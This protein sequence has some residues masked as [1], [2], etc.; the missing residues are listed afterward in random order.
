MPSFWKQFT[1]PFKTVGKTIDEWFKKK[2][3]K[4]P[5]KKAMTFKVGAGLT[6]E[7]KVTAEKK[8]KELTKPITPLKHETTKQLFGVGKRVSP[9]PEATT[10]ALKGM[11]TGVAKGLTLGY[12][13]PKFKKTEIEEKAAKI[14]RPIG[15]MESW[16]IPFGAAEKGLAIAGKLALKAP[17][18]A[19]IAKIGTK[20]MP[21]LV[22]KMA[23]V[24]LP[25][26]AISG[27]ERPT[28]GQT[29]EEAVAHGALFGAAFPLAG[30]ALK[31]ITKPMMKVASNA[32][33]GLV[34]KP[35]TIVIKGLP[36]EEQETL[37]T[38]GIKGE[39]LAKDIYERALRVTAGV[40]EIAKKEVSKTTALPAEK[41]AKK[42]INPEIAKIIRKKGEIITIPSKISLEVKEKAA[43]I[44]EVK[45]AIEPYMKI[46][47][48]YGFINQ[49]KKQGTI[50]L[51]EE[52][53]DLG[54][55]PQI[56][57]HPAIRVTYTVRPYKLGYGC[58]G[59]TSGNV[60][61]LAKDMAQKNGLNFE[62]IAK[63]V[64]P[65]EPQIKFI[66]DL[67]KN[68]AKETIIPGAWGK[69][70]IEM[71]IRDLHEINYHSLA[72]A[73]EKEVK[74]APKIKPP[75]KPGAKPITYT[76]GGIPVYAD[77]LKI[78]P[79]VKSLEKY[80]HSKRLEEEL[81]KAYRTFERVDT[82]P[83]DV[84]NAG[85]V[86]KF[87]TD[88]K[89]K[90][91]YKDVLDTTLYIKPQHHMRKNV[92][93]T[94]SVDPKGNPAIV[95]SDGIVSDDLDRILIE[96]LTHAKQYKKGIRPTKGVPY[97]EMP[98][99][100]RAK[101]AAKHFAPKTTIEDVIEADSKI[102]PA[103]MTAEAIKPTG[104]CYQQSFDY[105]GKHMDNESLRLVQG[106]VTGQG[107][108]KGVRY[109]HSWIEKGDVVIDTSRGNKK[110]PK[111][112]YYAL[113]EIKESEV[114]RY[115]PKQ[116]MEM[117]VET[118]HYGPWEVP[119]PK[120]KQSK[121]KGGSGSKPKDDFIESL[122]E[123]MKPD[124]FTKAAEKK[125]VNTGKISKGEK[126]V[127]SK[128]TAASVKKLTRDVEALGGLEK[129][130]I[131]ELNELGGYD[132]RNIK[133]LKR[134]L[135]KT[136]EKITKRAM[137]ETEPLTETEEKIMQKMFEKE[138]Q[139]V[140]KTAEGELFG[141]IKALGGIKP[142][143]EGFLAEEMSGIPPELLNKKGGGSAIDELVTELNEVGG[144]NFASEAELIEAI[145]S[146]KTVA[147]K[148]STK[149]KE[150]TLRLIGKALPK[151]EKAAKISQRLLNKLHR[152]K[153]KYIPAEAK[154]I[155]RA[156]EVGK[157][158]PVREWLPSPTN[159]YQE[160]KIS[161]EIAKYVS[162]KIAE[163]LKPKARFIKVFKDQK[164][165]LKFRPS[166]IKS[167]ISRYGNIIPESELYDY[168]MAYAQKRL[169]RVKGYTFEIIGSLKNAGVRDE[170]INQLKV[171]NRYLK[172]LV[173][174][175]REETGEISATISQKALDYIK[176]TRQFKVSDEEWI[177][178]ISFENVGKETK[179]IIQG[180]ETG[181]R[182]FRRLGKGFEELIFNPIRRG[183]R[184]A[185]ERQYYLKNAK[186][187]SVFDLSKKEA[188][189]L[190]A[191][192]ANKQGKEIEAK[193]WSELSPK[194]KKAYTDIRRTTEELYPEVKR[195]TILRGREIGE[196][197]NYSPLYI[198]RDIKRL[199]EGS[200][201]DWLRKDPYFGSIKERVEDVPIE[202]YEQ[203]YRKVIDQWIHGVSRYID[204][205][206]RTVPVKYLIDSKEFQ[207]IA[208]GEAHKAIIEWY[209]YI[210]NPPKIEGTWKG[211]R[212][213]RNL[214]AS[215]ILGLRYTVPL[216]QFINLV[217]FW[218]VSGIKNLVKGGWKVLRKSPVSRLAKTSGSVQERTMGLAIQ[219]LKN[220][221]I[222]W[223]R[224]PPEYTD[225]LTAQ[226]GKVTLIDQQ[227]A[228]L[229][230]EGKRITPKALKNAEKK[231]DDIIDAVM[232]AMSRAETPRYFRTELGKNIN[233]FY[234]QLNSKMQYYVSDIFAKQYP[235]LA[236]FL[237]TG[238]RRK[239]LAKA[240]T[241][242]VI[243]GYMETAINNLAFV[244][245]PQEM[246]KDTLKA[247]AGNFPLVGSVIFAL[248]TEQP[249]SPMP[250]LGNTTKLMQNIAQG[251]TGEAIW[252][253][254]GFLGMPQQIKKTAQGIKAVK[255]G[256][257]TTKA[258]ELQYPV[259]GFWEQ[260]RTAL[261]GKYGSKA[262]KEHFREQDEKSKS[263]FD[264]LYTKAEEKEGKR[265]DYLYR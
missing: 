87:I 3:E 150:K 196:V 128:P 88:P 254:T 253:G 251:R 212:V 214:Q 115:T 28:E 262:A 37:K 219:D 154:A 249:Y 148:I 66:K 231:A 149:A 217:D 218:T 125:P 63:K 109:G 20:V 160:E 73:L 29:R 120:I 52:I 27:L 222:R 156:M 248:T 140:K 14:T 259:K 68:F 138:F 90:K 163:T 185:K 205:G 197:K 167:A 176:K 258:G 173:K 190:F 78:K 195:V 171:E 49:G 121:P 213:L 62:T 144:Y 242:L 38:L 69:K 172:D 61:L 76:P 95:L 189:E 265:F 239:L 224:K 112:F 55:K 186:L 19:K 122:K 170:V 70:E 215:A 4:K 183:E 220:T 111:D 135:G 159:L 44:N 209:R 136:T 43:A 94:L 107:K 244:D 152:A 92:H 206:K 79:K 114:K 194:V 56:V 99:E 126:A 31:P 238:N 203:D 263:K 11:A 153:Y 64:Y 5:E 175:K 8:T 26:A 74:K 228:R 221:I 50:K 177:K 178:R 22:K 116:A 164:E 15:E 201:F 36:K 193:S 80:I 30:A 188:K 17:K 1:S 33:K 24:A 40:K 180:Y 35:T 65:D 10:G 7:Q 51:A 158:K 155:R 247:I 127:E 166:T 191:L 58:D 207:E 89:V 42:A 169:S 257:V 245:E 162:G 142:Y 93:A 261:A 34:K 124:E 113:G 117:A 25:F 237:K 130:D 134:A 85:K 141:S 97:K 255:E 83:K 198:T 204:I 82:T 72:D 151:K 202:F 100:I 106:N 252:T 16:L 232:G 241:A 174:V 230:Q 168:E 184:L 260:F 84:I 229:E 210:V 181:K 12:W 101:K 264:Y 165:T 139:K 192:T 123:I 86:G 53:A 256:E 18:I 200:L 2:T 143:R 146:I 234:S 157:Y 131:K 54:Y 9:I 102:K 187:K 199:D 161:P 223:M 48:G 104:E 103:K 6:P 77:N 211:L 133:E 226:M 233:M 39:N 227:L 132:F 236:N 98:E 108:I 235:E 13:F 96:E 225:R 147:E 45:K 208:G 60:M 41:V 145:K 240:I 243:G 67:E 119:E 182:F 118:K 250:I 47:G 23:K 21:G 91:Q 81:E 71:V 57:P 105:I 129:I 46:K 59:S 246:G 216:K 75:T 137:K 32:L 179:N 110:Y